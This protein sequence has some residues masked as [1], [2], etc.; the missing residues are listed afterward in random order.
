MKGVGWKG[1]EGV[2]WAGEGGGVC[3][4]IGAYVE[5]VGTR[6]AGRG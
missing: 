1:G 6:G 4:W 2:G 5:G 3:V